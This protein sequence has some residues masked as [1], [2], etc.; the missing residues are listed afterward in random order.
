MG[1]YSIDDFKKLIVSKFESLRLHFKES[2]VVESLLLL[3]FCRWQYGILMDEQSSREGG[4]LISLRDVVQRV[5]EEDGSSVF[6]GYFLKALQKNDLTMASDSKGGRLL[7]ELWDELVRLSFNDQSEEGSLGECFEWL[8]SFFAEENM[9]RGGYF[10]T[11]SGIV[12][13]IVKILD[14]KPGE[15]IYDPACGSG[16]FLVEAINYVRRTSPDGELSILGREMS[17]SVAF[18]AKT[19]VLIHGV[20]RNCIEVKSFLSGDGYNAKVSGRFDLAVA[21]PPFS[22]RNWDGG[23][24]GE[25]LRYGVPPQASA[26][27]AFIQN[28]L[29]SLNDEGRAAI[30]VPM[31]VLFRGGSEKT[32]REKM[33]RENNVEAILSIPSMS[34]YGTAIPANI[35]FLRSRCASGEVLFI[36]ASSFFIKSQRLNRLDVDAVERLFCLYSDR[37]DV[38]GVARCV[39]IAE[40]EAN[41]WDL[42]V[43][44]YV[45]PAPSVSNESL[46]FLTEQQ[47]KLEQELS[48]LQQEMR[49]LLSSL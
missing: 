48:F 20:V 40:L 24:S 49:R 3:M 26:D 1:G 18:V 12:S 29:F 46:A 25:F 21:N 11:P 8:L 4:R 16:E 13:L 28:L 43:S 22:L 7:V 30:I 5:A 37:K 47:N 14:P 32:I 42:T 44:K 31:G 10:F 23:E 36:D 45:V 41:G 39:S 35:L 19:N 34:F 38:E 33:L 6:K 9:G 2:D 27:F 17:P 15:K